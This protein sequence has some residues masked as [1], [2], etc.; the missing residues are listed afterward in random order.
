MLAMTGIIVKSHNTGMKNSLPGSDNTKILSTENL[1]NRVCL[2]KGQS[3]YQKELTK[4]TLEAGTCPSML[5][6]NMHD[7]HVLRREGL[8]IREIEEQQ[9]KSERTNY[10]YL[11][12]STQFC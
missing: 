10:H 2:K 4:I 6:L 12:E 5:D 3:L 8:K 9:G 7:T 11:E 1:A